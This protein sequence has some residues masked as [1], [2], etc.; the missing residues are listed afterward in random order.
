MSRIII[1]SAFKKDEEVAQTFSS[2]PADCYNF[3]VEDIEKAIKLI[4]EYAEQ[5][6]SKYFILKAG[7]NGLEAKPISE[8][9]GKHL[10]EGLRMM[11]PSGEKL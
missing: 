6:K 8:F 7:G 9:A 5:T 10:W 3:G 1:P 2:T 4:E 11:P